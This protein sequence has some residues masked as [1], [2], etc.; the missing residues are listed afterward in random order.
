MRLVAAIYPLAAYPSRNPNIG[1]Y[2]I[3]S[4]PTTKKNIEKTAIT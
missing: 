2:P 4:S 3:T 1:T